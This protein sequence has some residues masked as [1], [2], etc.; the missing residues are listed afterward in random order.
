MKRHLRAE[1]LFILIVLTDCA[2]VHVLFS[3][4]S[5]NEILLRK[6][7]RQFLDCRR[8]GTRER[9]KVIDFELHW[10]DMG[11]CEQKEKKK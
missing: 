9:E 1:K 4:D 8:K 5:K 3:S 2:I 6:R 7:I 10:E 11:Q